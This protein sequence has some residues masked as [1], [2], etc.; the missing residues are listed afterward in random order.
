MALGWPGSGR[1]F[2]IAMDDILASIVSVSQNKTICNNS[3]LVI[4]GSRKAENLR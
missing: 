1:C 4:P 3:R 2:G